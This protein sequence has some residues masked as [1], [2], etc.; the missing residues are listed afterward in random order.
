MQ[1]DPNIPIMMA[2]LSAAFTPLRRML[3]VEE[4]VVLRA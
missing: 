2:K 1:P 3:G 4:A